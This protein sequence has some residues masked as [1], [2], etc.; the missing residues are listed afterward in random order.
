MYTSLSPPLLPFLPPLLP[1]L[2]PPQRSRLLSDLLAGVF[3]LI[4]VTG[5]NLT[6]L[7]CLSP[8]STELVISLPPSTP[9]PLQY[10][11]WGQ[12]GGGGRLGARL[13]VIHTEKNIPC[14]YPL[15]LQ[16]PAYV[17]YGITCVL[18]IV[19]HYLLPHI[20]KETP[21][22]CCSEPIVKAKEWDIFEVSGT[23]WTAQY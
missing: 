1:P 23:Y 11:S 10:E 19:N 15:P 20:R 14:L 22:L 17:I 13:L 21:W 8:V 18:G 6:T 5:L 12:E 9:Q 7:F 2:P 3:I 16:I 4:F